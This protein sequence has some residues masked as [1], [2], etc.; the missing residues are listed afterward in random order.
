M[1]AYP[2][3]PVHPC[4]YQPSS[5]QPGDPAVTH[6]DRQGITLRQHCAGLAMQGLLASE[7]GGLDDAGLKRLVKLAVACA[8]ALLR[9]L[10]E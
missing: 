9:A 4:L 6:P 10:A 5:A 8:D 1:R 7:P 2:D 3:A